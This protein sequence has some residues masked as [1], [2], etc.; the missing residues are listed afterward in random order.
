MISFSS[1]KISINLQIWHKLSQIS[2]FITI[3][4]FK[5]EAQKCN[6]ESRLSNIGE[7]ISQKWSSD[8]IS[9]CYF[10][11]ISHIFLSFFFLRFQRVK[12]L[13]YFWIITK[14]FLRLCEM[15]LH[16]W[17]QQHSWTIVSE[18]SSYFFAHLRCCK[19]HNS[20]RNQE[21]EAQFKYEPHHTSEKCS[22]IFTL[23]SLTL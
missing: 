19:A 1:I 17:E 8:S 16:I 2:F 23:K 9:I 13:C 5:F 21:E 15:F 3:E 10:G 20:Q 22:A 18:S 12:V 11:Y 14:I 6:F 4:L 7:Y